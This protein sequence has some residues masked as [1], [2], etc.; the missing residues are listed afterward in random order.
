MQVQ[1]PDLPT[2]D[3]SLFDGAEGWLEGSHRTQTSWDTQCVIAVPAQAEPIPVDQPVPTEDSNKIL[4]LTEGLQVDVSNLLS[5]GAADNSRNQH[6]RNRCQKC[7]RHFQ[8]Q[9][10]LAAHERTCNKPPGKN[11]SMH[12][13]CPKC[14]QQ[15]QFSGHFAV[16][17]RTCGKAIAQQSWKCGKC[18]Q[19]FLGHSYY[20]VHQARCPQHQYKCL[21][22]NKAFASEQHYTAHTR[23]CA[24]TESKIASE[25]N[26]EIVVVNIPH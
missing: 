7:Q 8:N 6:K 20:Q 23:S 9:N 10:R 19:V 14:E 5:C 4:E 25:N 21:L 24:T 13:A 11:N 15:F 3:D 2:C 18:K 22:C 16:H 1:S 17:L 26:C 12:F